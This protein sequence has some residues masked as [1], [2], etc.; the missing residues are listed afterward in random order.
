[1]HQLDEGLKK[2]A[3]WCSYDYNLP[4]QIDRKH[5]H[6]FDCV[7][8][9]GPNKMLLLLLLLTI[10]QVIDPPFITAEVWRQYAVSANLLLQKSPLTRNIILTTIA[11]NQALLSE[12]LRVVP[13]TFRPSIPNLVYQY[14][15]FTN[16]DCEIL[17]ERNPLIP[18]EE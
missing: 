18:D 10:L 13:V 9:T 4:T 1:M 14:E 3:N 11:E 5:H 7:V 16:F 15:I 8:S 12:L 2:K 17:N 6:Q